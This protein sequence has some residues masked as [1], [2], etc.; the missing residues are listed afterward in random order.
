[1]DKS[2]SALVA[3]KSVCL[4]K[5][6]GGLGLFDI[7]SRNRSFLTK[8]I[9]NIHSQAD[10]L[11]VKWINHYYLPGQTI[12]DA[13]ATKMASPLWK[14]L[15]SLK[16]QLIQDFGSSSSATDML[17]S[18]NTGEGTFS[19]KAYDHF[20]PKGQIV[21][22]D[23]VVWEQWSLPKHCFVL[24]LAVLGKLRT[25]DRLLYMS[26]DSSCVFCNQD[27]ESH[28]HL[29]F[30]CSW[31][32]TLWNNIVQ[33]LHI[34]HR[35]GSLS[36]ALRRLRPKRKLVLSRMR[37]ASLAISVYLIWEERNKRVFDNSFSSVEKVFRR[38]QVL[39][40]MVFHFHDKD[41]FSIDVG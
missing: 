24:W 37:R 41:H 8:H 34:H 28:R 36:S 29:F 13:Q 11:W 18:W 4:P 22:W 14:I 35:M 20:R 33:W 12:W 16:N 7:K 21:L 23:R 19:A 31:S 1:V 3:W 26:A 2:H 17:S 32:S 5:Q 30:K 40:F 9:W 27:Q 10:S 38:F 15:V 6:E 39:F 25:K